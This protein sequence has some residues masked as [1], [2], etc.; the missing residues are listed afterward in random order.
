[1]VKAAGHAT[2]DGRAGTF[3]GALVGA[4]IVSLLSSGL[5]GQNTVANAKEGAV[6]V[7]KG[8]ETG[9]AFYLDA[10]RQSLE[11]RFA[12]QDKRI[13]ELEHR[14]GALTLLPAEPQ[15][16]LPSFEVRP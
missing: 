9:T 2:S 13:A 14:L 12:A 16:P 10:L 11:A 15:G 4:V 8:R 5:L 3:W 7:A 1:V 6:A